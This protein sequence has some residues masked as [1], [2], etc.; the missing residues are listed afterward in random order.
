MKNESD[1]L[2]S[3]RALAKIIIP[4]VLQNM[5]SIIIGA[6]TNIILDPIFIYALDI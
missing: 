5:L 2:F 1:S 4:L 6:V 3:G